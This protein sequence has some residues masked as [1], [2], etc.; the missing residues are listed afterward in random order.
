[1]SAPPSAEEQKAHRQLL[2]Q[3]WQR[4]TTILGIA[5]F[6]LGAAVPYVA[7]VLVNRHSDLG[8][9]DRVGQTWLTL[10]VAGWFAALVTGVYTVATA[11]GI[12]R[13]SRA[14]WIVALVIP[15]STVLAAV[16]FGY[17]RRRTLR[18]EVVALEILP[19]RFW[20]RR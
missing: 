8:I 3:Q 12:Q 19:R 5:A 10:L 2:L 11:P 20:R 9:P 17:T 16:A 18:D 6:T 1:M 4:A 7:L 15:P 14:A 13:E